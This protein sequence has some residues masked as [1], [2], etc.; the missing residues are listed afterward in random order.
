MCL[1]NWSGEGNSILLQGIFPTQGLNLRLLCLLLWQVDSLPP[2]ATWEGESN[3]T[4]LQ[5]SGLEKPM[6]GGA[7]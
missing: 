4:P 1:S 2:N 3:D 5:Y 6:D 7:W